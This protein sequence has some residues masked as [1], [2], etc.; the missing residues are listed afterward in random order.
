[1][2]TTFRTGN[3]HILL[4]VDRASRFPFAFP[5]P[6]KGLKE[7]AR[8]LANLCLTFGVPRNFR[9]DGGGEFRSEVLKSLYH[10]LKARLDFGPV[11]DSR[12]QGAVE[13]FGGGSKRCWR[14]FVEPGPTA[15]TSTL[16]RRVGSNV[17]CQTRLY[18]QR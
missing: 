6:S 16:P 2:E 13:R 5:L 8:I 4:V 15:G 17:P 9:S 11:D 7:V 18:S 10:W 12:G 3:Q 14:S 1:M